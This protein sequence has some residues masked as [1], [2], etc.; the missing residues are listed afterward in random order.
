LTRD[1]RKYNGRTDVVFQPKQMSAGEL[2]AGFQYANA[3]FYSLRSVAK[4]VRQ[5]PVQMWWVL[6]LNLAYVVSWATGNWGRGPAL[7]DDQSPS[8]ALW[9]SDEPLGDRPLDSL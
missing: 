3:R 9:S 2:L 8:R 1:W 6:P 5:S 4:R 7:S